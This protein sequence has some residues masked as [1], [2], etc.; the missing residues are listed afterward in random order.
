MKIISS[1]NDK[2]EYLPIKVS[3]ILDLSLVIFEERL[4]N[5][6]IIFELKNPDDPIVICNS[7]QISQIIIN[8][9]SNALDAMDSV[10]ENHS[11]WLNVSTNNK[12]KMTEIRVINSGNLIP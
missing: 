8:L 9:I 7:L 3:A 6:N 12:L 4:K 11:L 5:E 1:K 10:E 2:E